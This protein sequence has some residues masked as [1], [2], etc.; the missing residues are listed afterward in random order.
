MEPQN[1][2]ELLCQYADLE[3][4]HADQGF[5]SVTRNHSINDNSNMHAYGIPEITRAKKSGGEIR[6]LKTVL[7]S[8]CER[9]CN[10]CAFRAGRDF[11]RAT[12]KP[13]EMALLFHKMYISG[14]AEGLFLSSGMIGGGVHTQDKLIDTVEILRKKYNYRG[15]LHLKIMPGAEK[16]Q[17]QRAM[18]LASRVSINLEAPNPMRLEALAPKK[19]F[20]EEL[21]QRLQ[22]IEEIRQNFR[23]NNRYHNRWPSLATQFVVGSVG[24]TDLELL[25]TSEYLFQKFHLSRIFYS[26]FSP[27]MDTPFENIQPEKHIRQTRLYQASFLLKNYFYSCED[28][29]F[30][31]NGNL[32]LDMDPKLAWARENLISEPVEINSA[33][34]LQLLRVPGFGPK[35]VN[36]IIEA[37]Q[38]NPIKEV[39][40]IRRMGVDTDRALEYILI[41][42]KHPIQ[43]IRML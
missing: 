29:N 2:L 1:T 32:P 33:D 27:V 9:N 18:Q 20:M 3:E 30:L 43:Q 34:R 21:L 11:H 23:A 40:D 4:D 14:I 10:Y 17:V 37:R 25:S 19:I 8:A 22:W 28:L 41:N 13:D 26:R 38:K 7:T 42:G 35:G 16:D 6:L 39:G 24:E 31:Q 15:Y 12:M 36:A 5:R